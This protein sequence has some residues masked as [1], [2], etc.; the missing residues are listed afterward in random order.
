MKKTSMIFLLAA[1]LLFS[2]ASTVSAQATLPV[3]TCPRGFDP[4]MIGDM[5]GM[6]DM[7]HI[8]AGLKVDLNGD[9]W[10]CMKVATDGVHVHVDNF[11]MPR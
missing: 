6:T 4:H 1:V 5:G 8:H 2:L 9:G 11:V 3:G 7:D 10:I